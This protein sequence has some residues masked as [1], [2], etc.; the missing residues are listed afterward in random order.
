MARIHLIDGEKG[1]VGKSLFTRVM[2]QY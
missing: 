2:V 1:G